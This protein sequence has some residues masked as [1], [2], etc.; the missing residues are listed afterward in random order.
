[1]PDYPA[2]RI[3]YMLEDAQ[4]KILV[5]HDAT[6][7]RLPQTRAALVNLDADAG[8]ITS[9]HTSNLECATAPLNAAYVIYTSG[10]TGKPKGVVVTHANVA[11][12]FAAT[13]PWFEFSSSDVW[14]LFHSYAFDFSVWELWG[15]LLH[16]GRLEIV[17]YWLSRSPGELLNLLIDERVTVLNQ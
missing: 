4:I 6:Q 2:E 11:R 1:D 13:E 17:P 15:P 16:G 7:S 3:S 12:L 10:S 14:T 9:Q 5:I 8:L